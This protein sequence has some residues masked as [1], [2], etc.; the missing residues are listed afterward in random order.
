L[1]RFSFRLRLWYFNAMHRARASL[2]SIVAAA[3]LT[4]PAAASAHAR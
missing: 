2:A 4:M 3:L 1:P